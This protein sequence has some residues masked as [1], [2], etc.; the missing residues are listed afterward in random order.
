MRTPAEWSKQNETAPTD[1]ALPSALHPEDQAFS[2]QHQATVIRL[3]GSTIMQ[4][5]DP[6]GDHLFHAPSAQYG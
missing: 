6:C 3:I 2:H 1:S 4:E 5:D